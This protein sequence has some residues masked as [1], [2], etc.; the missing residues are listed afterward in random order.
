MYLT[1]N[2]NNVCFCFIVEI[3][4]VIHYYP[5]TDC[6]MQLGY[7]VNS[8]YDFATSEHC[9]SEMEERQLVVEY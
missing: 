1:E 6:M 4:D 5:N 8:A 9:H 2:S 3:V 7:F